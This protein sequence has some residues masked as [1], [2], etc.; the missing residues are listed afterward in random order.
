MKPVNGLPSTSEIKSSDLI[1]VL[2]ISLFSDFQQVKCGVF[3]SFKT[4]HDVVMV[5]VRV[6]LGSTPLGCYKKLIEYYQQGQISFQ[7]VKTFNMDEYVGEWI[8]Y[9]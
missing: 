8:F 5:F 2:I 1:P 7:Y 6:S 4:T 3:F 9:F